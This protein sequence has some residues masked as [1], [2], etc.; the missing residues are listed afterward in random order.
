MNRRIT[1]ALI[2]F[3]LLASVAAVSAAET[4][5][6]IATGHCNNGLGMPI[7]DCKLGVWFY[8]DGAGRPT[9]H[10]VDCIT[11]DQSGIHECKADYTIVDYPGNAIRVISTH[12]A[13]AHPHI[14]IGI[15]SIGLDTPARACRLYISCKQ[16][17]TTTQGEA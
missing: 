17:G 8:Y 10:V 11:T 15:G 13:Q 5:V 4:A 1:S 2:V 6:I 3:L 14:D 16:D 12:S 7:A 9:P